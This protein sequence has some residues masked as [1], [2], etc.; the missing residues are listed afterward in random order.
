ME[1]SSNIFKKLLLFLIFIVLFMPMLQNALNLFMVKN[2]K[3]SFKIVPDIDFF[4]TYWKNGVFQE[5]KEKYLNEHFGLRNTSVRINN[6]VKFNLFKKTNNIETVIGK[7]NYLFAEAYVESY[8]GENFV[9][10]EKIIEKC[11]VIKQLQE[12]MLERGK[13]FLPVLAPNKARILKEFLPDNV[14]V[15]NMTNYEAIVICFKKLKVNYIDFNDFFIKNYKTS[16]YPLYSKY[17]IHW[18]YYGHTLAADSIINY[19]NFYY[20]LNTPKL[21]WRKNIFLSDTLR[22]FDYDAGDGMNLFVDQLP[23]KKM[24]YVNYEYKDTA[25]TKPALLVVGDSY[26]YGLELTKMQKMVFSN[27]KFLYYFKELRPYSNDKEAFL[28]LS[29]KEEIENHQVFIMIATEHNLKNYGWGFAEKAL[30]VINGK[31]EEIFDGYTKEVK[32]MELTIRND[33]GWYEVLVHEAFISKSNIDTVIVEAARYKINQK[34][35]EKE[36]LTPLMEMIQKIKNDSHWINDVKV[37]AR[38]KN[39]SVDSAIVLDALW[40]MNLK[41]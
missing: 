33:K 34:Y 38:K 35:Q 11:R 21:N 26:N 6:Q 25:N 40:Q 15:K 31:E 16:V 4:I 17:G 20:H 28:K 5:N 27:Y 10:I 9:G 30:N 29:L 39:I 8:T 41:R 14:V 1:R 13:I 2:L 7:D 18:S 36:S 32:L 23:S 19:L 12:K 37:R 24:A 22:G 3:G